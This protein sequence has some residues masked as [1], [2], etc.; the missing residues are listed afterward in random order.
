MAAISQTVPAPTPPRRGRNIFIL[1]IAIL[2]ILPSL[3]EGYAVIW[4]ERQGFTAKA[5]RDGLDFW[6]GGFVALHHHVAT[7][8][9]PA[10]Y[11]TF[12]H[13][14]F[15]PAGGKLPTHM[16][17]YPPNYLLLAT[18]FGWLSPWHAVLAFDAASLLFLMLILRL[19]RL[20]WLLIAAVAFSP[21]AL[22]NILEGQNAALITALIGGGLLLME[23]R[24]RLS[25]ILI[26]LATI[27]PQLGLTLPLH[28][29]QRSRIGLLY[30]ALAA[31]LLA[32]AS[33]FAFGPGA[34]SAFWHVTRPAMSNVLLTGQPPEFA[35]GLISVF[36]TARGLGLHPALAIQALASLT[37]ILLAARTKNPVAV[38]I[39]AALA[40]PY[41]HVYDLLGVALAVAL[42][43]QDRLQ[44]GFAPG[45]PLLFF[46][47]W[48]RP[49][50][51]ALDAPIRPRNPHHPAPPI[52]KCHA[53]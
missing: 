36:A 32:A 34:W 41:L 31:A 53:P 10:A 29:L 33:V 18:A 37:A 12:I 52:G 5:L 9:N 4:G 11:E 3:A 16:W 28:L 14:T 49:R 8:F 22:E 39:L 42:L 1:A 25:G 46:L 45:E 40:S 20:P 19:A 51:P 48:G 47:C 44:R 21:V 27:K 23:T 2:S 17:S 24:P 35:G 38:L 15:P 13:G 6:A 26:G 50:R 7:V 43:V 30:A